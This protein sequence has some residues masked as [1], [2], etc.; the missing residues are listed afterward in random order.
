MVQVHIVVEKYDAEEEG[1]ESSCVPKTSQ[2]VSK[3][4]GTKD[5][6]TS[7]KSKADG[8][9]LELKKK[10]SFASFFQ[11]NW[12]PKKG[13]SLYKVENQQGVVN[14]D[15]EDM[16]DVIETWVILWGLVFCFDKEE[17]RERI[18]DEGP[19]IIYGRPLIL[20]HMP[21][22]FE[23]GNCTNTVIPIWIT[24]PGLPL[25][26]WNDHALPKIC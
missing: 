18:L 20:K 11:D 16:T 8:K 6:P 21:P 25:D 26:L 22:L 10:K 12:N 15:Y 14:I 2:S 19:Y 9:G 13:I 23:F 4:L 5:T 17:D 1:S 24:F 7:S 3:T